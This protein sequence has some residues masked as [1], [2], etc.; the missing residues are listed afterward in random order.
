MCSPFCFQAS[1]RVLV[2][3]LARWLARVQPCI[4]ACCLPG[5]TR[6][7]IDPSLEGS[8]SGTT[9]VTRT[10]GTPSSTMAEFGGRN[11]LDAAELIATGWLLLD[12]S[13]MP[14]VD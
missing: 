3:T 14:G 1:S 5:Y 11:R 2:P 9:R 8:V 12:L 13:L 10:T 4:L 6:G 7:W